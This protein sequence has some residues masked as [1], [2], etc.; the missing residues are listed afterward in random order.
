MS[1]L[2]LALVLACVCSPLEALT[3][4]VAT[5]SALINDCQNTE[6]GHGARRN[7]GHLTP[8][9][10]YASLKYQ[11]GVSKQGYRQRQVV[12]MMMNNCSEVVSEQPVD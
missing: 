1:R 4:P 7:A 11:A 9:L 3:L 6:I 12:E 8:L 5:L 2:H 10:I